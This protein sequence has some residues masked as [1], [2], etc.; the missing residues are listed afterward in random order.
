MLNIIEKVLHY[1]GIQFLRIDGDTPNKKR[2]PIVDKFNSD[3][4]ITVCLFTTGAGSEGLTLTGASRVIIHDCHWNPKQDEQAI[5][6]IYRIG[7]K[8]EV[9]AYYL[10]AAGTVEGECRK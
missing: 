2:Q 4:R 6:R 5:H 10:V 8:R 7:Q 9:E 3:T 1:H